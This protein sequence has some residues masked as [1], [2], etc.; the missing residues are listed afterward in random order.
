[1]QRARLEWLN[2]NLDLGV[3]VDMVN[4]RER[5]ERGVTL[6]MLIHRGIYEY[7]NSDDWELA[8]R[9]KAPEFAEMSLDS[10]VHL[11]DRERRRERYRAEKAAATQIGKP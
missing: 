8:D 4:R 3:S 6:A 5:A 7:T 9:F 11:V 2:F 10:L 1:M